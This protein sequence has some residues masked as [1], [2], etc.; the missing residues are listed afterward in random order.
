MLGLGD[1]GLGG[2]IA[3]NNLIDGWSPARFGR[4]R[5]LALPD[6]VNLL[7]LSGHIAN[8]LTLSPSNESLS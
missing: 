5:S 4:V 6:I 3:I 8:T 7:T 2:R 1:E